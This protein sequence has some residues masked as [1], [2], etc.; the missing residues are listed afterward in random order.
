MLSY[1]TFF[2]ATSIKFLRSWVM[3]LSKTIL[4]LSM[5]LACGLGSSLVQVVAWATMIPDQLEKTGD[6]M[7]AIENTF[8]GGHACSMCEAAAQMRI[9]ELDSEQKKGSDT[10]IKKERKKGVESYYIV[11][12]DRS[13]KAA[14]KELNILHAEYFIRP[15]CRREGKVE[16]PP[17]QFV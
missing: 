5:C 3:V 9:A 14:F 8:S 2:K 6:V 15:L 16:T 12:L 10:P 4:V 17:P 7:T 1:G 11:S 13:V